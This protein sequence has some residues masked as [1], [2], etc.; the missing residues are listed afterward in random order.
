M[1]NPVLVNLFTVLSYKSI[2]IAC[3]RV[4]LISDFKCLT[5]GLVFVWKFMFAIDCSTLLPITRVKILEE[6][7]FIFL[8]GRLPLSKLCCAAKRASDKFAVADHWEGMFLRKRINIRWLWPFMVSPSLAQSWEGLLTI[9]I[10][11]WDSCLWPS[12]L[13]LQL[14]AWSLIN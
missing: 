9:P 4:Y 8:L 3:F 11:L 5:S 2:H 12:I 1:P 6:R 10:S 14:K 7:T 13:S